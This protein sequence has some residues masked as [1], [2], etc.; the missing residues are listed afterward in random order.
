MNTLT[1]RPAPKKHSVITESNVDED[2]DSAAAKRASTS[3]HPATIAEPDAVLE[4]PVVAEHLI[5]VEQSD[6]AEHGHSADL[7]RTIMSENLT[8]ASKH[9]AKAESSQFKTAEPH[10]IMQQSGSLEPEHPVGAEHL[11]TTEHSNAGERQFTNEHLEKTE[12]SE[13]VKPSIP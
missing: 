1:E 3:D 5:P 10:I 7:V 8:T 4:Q 13:I 2:Y 6:A 12:H 11:A 9:S